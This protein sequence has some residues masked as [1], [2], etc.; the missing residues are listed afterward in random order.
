MIKEYMVNTY[1]FLVKAGRRV[2]EDIPESYQI[3]VAEH[4]A[5][6]EEKQ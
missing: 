4:L 1:A 3:P 2:I 5:T 6:Q